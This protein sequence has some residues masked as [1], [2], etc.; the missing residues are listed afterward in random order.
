MFVKLDPE[1]HL[2]YNDEQL[3]LDLLKQ[4]RM[5]IVHGTGFNLSD[6]QHYRFVF[7]PR[8]D[9]LEDAINRFEVFLESYEQSPEDHVNK[10]GQK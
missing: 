1:V 9:V 2:I 3:V 6:Q 10:P 4:Q 5:L 7:L 8:I